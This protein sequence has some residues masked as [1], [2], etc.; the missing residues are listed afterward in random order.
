MAVLSGT[1]SGNSVPANVGTGDFTYTVTTA[2]GWVCGN[3]VQPFVLD[4]ALLTTTPP[5]TAGRWVLVRALSS[6]GGIVQYAG[7]TVTPPTG[8]TVVGIS[9]ENVNYSGTTYDC[10]VVTLR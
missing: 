8:L 9:R 3:A 5:I 2:P 6:A 4:D 1:V 7:A 10:I